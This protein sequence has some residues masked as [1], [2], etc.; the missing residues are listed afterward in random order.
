M[1]HWML[2]YSQDTSTMLL[3]FTYQVQCNLLYSDCCFFLLAVEASHRENFA[4]LL[5]KNK[6]TNRQKINNVSCGVHLRVKRPDVMWFIWFYFISMILGGYIFQLLVL[7]LIFQL[8]VSFI[9]KFFKWLIKWSGEYCC[10]S[11]QGWMLWFWEFSCNEKCF[12]LF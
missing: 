7:F 1:L 11:Y 12:R 2:S 3:L 10:S 5:K 9:R 6:S 4:I 8:E